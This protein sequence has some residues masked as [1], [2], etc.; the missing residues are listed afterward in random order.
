MSGGPLATMLRGTVMAH[1]V[2]VTFAP[3]TATSGGKIDMQRRLIAAVLP[4]CLIASGA[5][6]QAV[7][8][9]PANLNAVIAD[10]AYNGTFGSMRCVNVVVT[11][12][13]MVNNL[14]VT[15]AIDHTWV[16]DLVLKLISPDNTVVTLMSVPGAAEVADDGTGSSPESSNLGSAFPVSFV[17]NGPKSSELMGSN[18]TNSQVVCKD[19]LACVYDPSSGA[20]APGKLA[21]YNGKP[22]AGTWKFCAGDIGIGDAGVIQQVKLVFPAGL[23]QIAPATTD[24]GTQDL[25]TTSAEKFVTLS[26][27]GNSA[28]S[29]DTLTVAAAPF[30]RTTSGTCGNSLPRTLAIGESCTL[31]YTFAPTAIGNASQVFT[32]QTTGGGDTGFTLTGTGVDTI[33]MNGFE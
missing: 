24:C 33:F 11:G 22:S 23:L 14:T 16:G 7:F 32:L 21:S 29:I 12:G 10:D 30:A 25:G 8:Q 20:A 4:L 31:S 6:G 13:I 17:D 19:D 9:T 1:S 27:S 26:N 2:G 28:M 15:A 3:G 18:I 5:R